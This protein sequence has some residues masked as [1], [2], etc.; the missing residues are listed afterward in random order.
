MSTTTPS[1][2]VTGQIIRDDDDD[3]DGVLNTTQ[4]IIIIV[5]ILA[6]CIFGAIIA[7]AVLAKRSSRTVRQQTFIPYSTSLDGH[8][9]V[10]MTHENS[11]DT[12]K[13]PRSK[14]KTMNW[15]LSRRAREYDSSSLPGNE[16]RTWRHETTAQ[17]H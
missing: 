12:Y 9:N 8:S 16:E 4:V 10:S 5:A 3:D 2:P 15:R 14:S 6:V 17:V 7:I 11:F 13:I 1:R